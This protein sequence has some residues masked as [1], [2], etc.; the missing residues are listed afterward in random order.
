MWEVYYVGT[1]EGRTIAYC[2]NEKLANDVMCTYQEG[3]TAHIDVRELP[4]FRMSRTTDDFGF[5]VFAEEDG[6]E[7]LSTEIY[8]DE[9][10][11]E[12]EVRDCLTDSTRNDEQQEIVIYGLIPVARLSTQ[13]I[14]TETLY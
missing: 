1:W 12:M 10:S 11:A 14:Q 2:P 5:F 7:L 8:G 3:R 9:E 4:E 6:I 13:P